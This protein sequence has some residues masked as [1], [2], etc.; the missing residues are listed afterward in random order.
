MPDEIIQTLRNQI[1]YE[2]GMLAN[3]QGG[4]TSLLTADWSIEKQFYFINGMK[5]ALQIVENY[6]AY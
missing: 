3:W 1:D 2:E 4:D 5:H 6:Q